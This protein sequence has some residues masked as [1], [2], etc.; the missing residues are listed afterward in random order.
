MRVSAIVFVALT[1]LAALALAAPAIHQVEVAKLARQEAAEDPDALAAPSKAPTPKA[2]DD[3]FSDEDFGPLPIGEDGKEQPQ[4]IDENG[5]PFLYPV[6]EDGNPI[7][8]PVDED[9]NIE[10]PEGVRPRG[11]PAPSPD[12][13]ADTDD[14]SDAEASPEVAGRGTD[15]D[16]DGDGVN[17]GAVVGGVIGGLAALALIAGL[18]IA[19]TRSKPD[20]A[21][22][23][24]AAAGGAPPSG[25]DAGVVMP[26]GTVAAGTAGVGGAA[27]G[28]AAVASET[29]FEAATV[30]GEGVGAGT[31]AAAGV[32][33]AAV[34]AGVA[35]AAI[36]AGKKDDE[37]EHDY[38]IGSGPTETN[39]EFTDIKDKFDDGAAADG[40][41]GS[42]TY[43]R[44][45]PA[46]A[47]A[48]SSA[49]SAGY[50][51]GGPR[52]MLIASPSRTRNGPSTEAARETGVYSELRDGN[53]PGVVYESQ[54]GLDRSG[55]VTD[56][57]GV[58]RDSAGNVVEQ[59]GEPDLT[60]D[61]APGVRDL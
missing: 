46:P 18:A 38:V 31:A 39:K 3:N 6:D 30:A 33:A 16:G 15:V 52:G 32:G 23:A 2:I 9:G 59:V 13:D 29:G 26:D 44:L 7:P 27:V 36:A 8:Y 57:Q 35:G 25:G 47:Y 22:A 12:V 45:G 42:N 49:S 4:L 11:T 28:G 10:F 51:L 19:F 61:A 41:I 5:E 20:D 17:V 55:L 21:A 40:A 60:G 14:D 48:G 50:S 56:A 54:E 24:A 53:A 34:G 43:N 37:P 1:A 58:V